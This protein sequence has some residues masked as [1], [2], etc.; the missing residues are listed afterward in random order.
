M[1]TQ[2]VF[3]CLVII[4]MLLWIFMPK[5]YGHLFA[6]L[7]VS[8][9]VNDSL[10]GSLPSEFQGLPLCV[11]GTVLQLR[12]SRPFW[13]LILYVSHS[14]APGNLQGSLFVQGC[15]VSRWSALVW[16]SSPPFSWALMGAFNQETLVSPGGFSWITYLASCLLF[17]CSLSVTT[18]TWKLDLLEVETL[19]VSFFSPLLHKSLGSTFWEIPFNSSS[20]TSVEFLISVIR[21]FISQ[22]SF[23]HWIF[24]FI[25]S[26]AFC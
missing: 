1:D 20:D 25:Y 23:V 22:S 8:S 3:H 16:A 14:S 17:L 26:M 24:I 9:L 12:S 18:I 21:F 5:L 15:A 4:I 13:I 19:R 2:G 6:I 10:A 7:L 11:L